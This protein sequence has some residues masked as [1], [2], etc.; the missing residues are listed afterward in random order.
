MNKINKAEYQKILK[1]PNN[2]IKEMSRLCSKWRPKY[3]Y[4]YRSLESSFWKDELEKGE[5]YLSPCDKFNDPFEGLIYIDPLQLNKDSWII[6]QV[7]RKFNRSTD[8]ILKKL[9]C[10]KEL[11]E[12]IKHYQKGILCT[13]FSC[14]YD[15]ILMWAHYAD[16]GN[17]ICI[18]YNIDRISKKHQDRILPVLYDEKRIDVTEVVKKGP[19]QNDLIQPMITKAK[20]WDYEEEWR[21]LLVRDFRDEKY[22]QGKV[23][24]EL[25]AIDGINI[26]YNC[27]DNDRK[28]IINWANENKKDVFRIE[29]DKKEAKLVSH[30]AKL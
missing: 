18:R 2:D 13:C 30:K 11:K 12:I 26:G 8:Y 9:R 25:E 15:N 3:L 24:T 23:I 14:S 17:G 29:I 7:S 5:I 6:K 19:K 27:S 10:E 4:R 1:N 28:E 20:E 16:K 22:G 21:I